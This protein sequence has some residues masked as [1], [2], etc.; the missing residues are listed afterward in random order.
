MTYQYK[1]KGT[2]STEINFDII[3]D[4]VRNVTYTGGC[5]GNLKAVA[6]LVDGMSKSEVEAKLKGI[7]CGMKETSCADQ[8]ATALENIKV[9]AK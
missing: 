3:D 9:E 2:C 1:T 7:K 8:L 5:N 6:K 4:K